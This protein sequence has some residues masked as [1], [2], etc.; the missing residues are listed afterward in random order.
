MTHPFPGQCLSTNERLKSCDE[1]RL[2]NRKCTREASGCSRCI[3]LSIECVYSKNSTRNKV[4]KLLKRQ[5][6][7]DVLIPAALSGAED[8]KDPACAAGPPASPHFS[9]SPTKPIGKIFSRK[10]RDSDQDDEYCEEKDQDVKEEDSSVSDDA[11]VVTKARKKPR[12]QPASARKR[13][14]RT[15]VSSP[16]AFTTTKPANPPPPQLT[17]TAAPPSTSTDPSPPPP[18]SLYPLST[19]HHALPTPLMTAPLHQSYSPAF[20]FPDQWTPTGMHSVQ[21]DAFPTL[22]LPGDWLPNPMMTSDFPPT[23]HHHH[24]DIMHSPQSM[25]PFYSPISY[26]SHALMPL[27]ANPYMAPGDGGGNVMTDGFLSSSGRTVASTLENQPLLQTWVIPS[28][29]E[30]AGGGVAPPHSYFRNP[31]FGSCEERV[32]DDAWEDGVGVGGRW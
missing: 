11:I 20:P 4:F 8:E 27:V 30:P 1:C 29:S 28:S 17:T 19:Y 31:Y 3:K 15:T 2:R 22:P 10:R 26:N 25:M 24:Q 32:L 16:L 23:F 14:R 18:H 21:Q 7:P 5:T 9:A 13:T 12:K 6:C